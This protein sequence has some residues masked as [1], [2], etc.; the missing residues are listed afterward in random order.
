MR[1]RGY[2][3]VEV[4]MAAAVIAIAVTAAA[5]II[6]TLMR[7]DEVNTA[8]RQGANLQEQAI[9]LY[10][11]GV[12][13]TDIL[14]LLPATCTNVALPP[15]GSVSL[16]F[17]SPTLTNWS[18]SAGTNDVRAEVSTCTLVM[19]RAAAG[20]TNALFMTNLLYIVQPLIR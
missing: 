14:A 9:V 6:N 15:E 8:S 13:P 7:Q 3:L 18:S 1:N 12:A 5:A 4:L 2:S 20:D 11:L 19:K 17:G 16:V 10:R